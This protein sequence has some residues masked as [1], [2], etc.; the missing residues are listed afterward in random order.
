MSEGLACVRCRVFL[1]PKR[2]GVVVEEGKPLTNDITGPWGPYKLWRA[3][4]AECPKCK[5]Q[6]ITGFAQRPIA[7][8]FEKGYLELLV[9]YKP[10]VRIDACTGFKP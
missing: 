5:F 7:E 9:K 1:V 8:H 3:D 6:L 4:L 10:I 2:S